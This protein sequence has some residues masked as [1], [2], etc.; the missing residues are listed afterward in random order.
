M[1]ARSMRDLTAEIVAA[2]V[3]R[4]PVPVDA[5]PALI[6]DVYCALADVAAGLTA[7]ANV[8]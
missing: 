7:T 4:N 8:R 5:L 1:T 2:H 6:Q 3:R